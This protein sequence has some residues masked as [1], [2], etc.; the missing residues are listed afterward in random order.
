[1]SRRPPERPG[2]AADGERV[3]PQPQ[4]LDRHH[5]TAAF[6]THEADLRSSQSW[7]A[8]A[9]LYTGRST[10]RHD[11]P[12]ERAQL[13][14]KLGTLLE[15]SLAQPKAAAEAYQEAAQ[16]APDAAEPLRRLRRVHGELG[17]HTTVLQIADAELSRLTH[18]EERAALLEE[19]AD[20]WEHE[21]SDAEQA[22]ALRAR[23]A[24]ER[25]DAVQPPH[26]VAIAAQ[27]TETGTAPSQQAW[28]AA[29][30]GKTSDA[31]M[32]LRSA[33][34]THP[35]DVE[36]IDMLVTL[37]EGDKRHAESAGWLERRA[38][39]ASD[40]TRPSILM[41]LAAVRE[42]LGDLAAARAAYEQA[43]EI[44]PRTLG[45]RP[46]LNRFYRTTEAWTR[47]R[48]FLDDW[49]R[50]GS[51]QE[52]IEALIALGELVESH[53]EDPDSAAQSFRQALALRAE[54]PRACAALAR[55]GASEAP[56]DT[57]ATAEVQRVL[58]VLGVLQRKLE[59]CEADGYAR[60]TETVELRLRIAEL[61]FE[62]M[63]DVV[64]A[65][66]VL[67][68][69]LDF[70]AGIDA[71]GSALADLYE[72]TARFD[73]L[74]E[75]AQQMAAREDGAE[76]MRWLYRAAA[77]AHEA[78]HADLAIASFEHILDETPNNPSAEKALEGLY[79]SQGNTSALVALLRR[80]LHR[81]DPAREYELHIELASHLEGPLDNAP[82]A[83]VHLSRATELDPSNF[84]LL[85][86]AL[87]VAGLVGGEMAQLDLLEHASAAAGEAPQR[88]ALVAKRATHMADSLGW[89]EEAHDGWNLARSLDPSC[90][91][92][93]DQLGDTP[94]P[95]A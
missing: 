39:L 43:L 35:D 89:T 83:L 61:Q 45:L 20:I 56:P 52:R 81:A 30:R 54:E 6:E 7:K 9:E 41:R 77:T 5:D 44:E 10:A 93:C 31:L 21:F 82:G 33:L 34:E 28:L 12:A 63:G 50:D 65:I 68:P 91:E 87:A 13:L 26:A 29:A 73:T 46:A 70:E 17:N 75:L 67:E 59:A 84:Q 80:S 2:G 88:A 85:E 53:F 42:E 90:A 25:G 64:G 58:P 86:H 22:D 36:S 60:T 57:E 14:L 16:L 24:A 78:G 37:L 55:L 47:I 76:R 38:R 23:A 48:L 3:N 49:S 19:T 8:L 92:A 4:D 66:E 79:R 95:V 1:M 32:M 94:P 51:E 40:E 18:S 15:R 72:H 62:S 74:T 69:L 11:H 71:A 27:P